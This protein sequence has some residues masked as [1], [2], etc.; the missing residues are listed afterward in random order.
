MLIAT[1]NLL[2]PLHS[3]STIEPA[4]PHNPGKTQIDLVCGDTICI[5][6]EYPDLVR[7]LG[8]ALKN[9]CKFVD[10]NEDEI[11]F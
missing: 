11:P 2:I 4:E 8:N 1:E 6:T 9:N 10:L 7:I 3:I 5:E